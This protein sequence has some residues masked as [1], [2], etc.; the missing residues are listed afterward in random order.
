MSSILF[1]GF[2][3]MIVIGISQTRADSRSFSSKELRFM[4]ATPEHRS[5][6][7]CESESA[8]GEKRFSKRN[9]R[10]GIEDFVKFFFSKNT[11][12]QTTNRLICKQQ[13]SFYQTAEILASAQITETIADW[14]SAAS[15]KSSFTDS[16]YAGW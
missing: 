9:S 6:P 12:P 4:E 1:V 5:D 15:R 2:V 16:G 7:A 13:S 14:V 10:E 8:E 3:Q 11:W